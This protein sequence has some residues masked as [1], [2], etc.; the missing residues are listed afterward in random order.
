MAV[1][2]KAPGKHWREG[3]SLIEF[4][5]MFPD[6]ET[7][8]RWFVETR[9]PDGIRCAH[10]GSDRV[11]TK[12]THPKMPYHCRD[13]RKFFS[14]RTGTAL[15][16]AKLGFRTIVLAMY[17]M[18]TGIKGT[19]SMK[20]HRDLNTTQ[21]TAWH[22]AHRLRETWD[23]SQT[24]FDGPVAVDEMYVGGLE[25]NKHKSK[26]K[27]PGGGGKGKAVVAGAVDHATGQVHAEV[28]E[29]TT[30]TELQGFV[31]KTAKPGA[32]VYTDEGKGYSGLSGYNH[33]KVK[34]S[35]GEYV[36]ETG[37]TT[38]A[39]EAQWSMFKR[40][41]H[42]T[43]HKMSDKHLHRYVNEFSGR[44]Y[45]RELGTM[46]QMRAIVMGI[47]GKELKYKDLVA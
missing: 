20:L 27:H 29:D 41:Y 45:D 13:C 44:H 43:Y 21:R 36:S 34:H 37:A 6:D 24:P 4:F 7:A 35:Q 11:N 3:I 39:V 28:I 42:G 17:L 25:G 5:N 2:K 32:T 22:L 15:R 40:G 19:S 47:E 38:N 33:D 26:K 18:T 8:E 23:K 30:A 10:C 46:D 9:W 12:A 31:H 14:P 1:V 16:S